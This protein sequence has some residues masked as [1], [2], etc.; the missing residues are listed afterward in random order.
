MGNREF[1][2]LPWE[3]CLQV[4]PGAAV[5]VGADGALLPFYG[6]TV[7]F[8]LDD[9]AKEQLE[10]LQ[11]RLYRRCGHFLSERLTADSFHVTLHDL[12]SGTDREEMLKQVT[13]ISEEAKAAVEVARK[14]VGFSMPMQPAKL[15]SMV[16]TSVVLLLEPIYDVDR[17]LLDRAYETLQ[18]VVKLGYGLTP[19][20]TLGY[21]RPGCIGGEDLQI[22][23]DTLS[24][25]SQS[26]DFQ[27]VLRSKHLH[28]REFWDMNHYVDSIL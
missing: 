26:L 11:D 12:L 14:L 17:F 4:A 18:S 10:Q 21:Y 3:N 9:T 22:L 2:Y 5:K 8:D 13:A 25:L 1:H 16:S 15:V 6:N 28:Y 23:A 20:V 7:I 19:H 24:E 27:V